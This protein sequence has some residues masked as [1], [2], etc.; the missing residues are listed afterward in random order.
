MVTNGTATDGNARVSE[1]SIDLFTERV[2]QADPSEG[3]GSRRQRQPS[4]ASVS[5]PHERAQTVTATVKNTDGGRWRC[6][7]HV[8]PS[9]A[10]SSRTLEE[11][12]VVNIAEIVDWVTPVLNII[13][14]LVT[15]AGW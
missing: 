1:I 15:E 12:Q 6:D 9:S 5:I 2:D 11:E 13:E 7:F 10:A 3:N 8:D 4:A 14:A